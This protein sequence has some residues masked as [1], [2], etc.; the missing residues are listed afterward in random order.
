MTTDTMPSIASSKARSY[1]R[2]RKRTSRRSARRR[3]RDGLRVT[4]PA[5]M[6]GVISG[7]LVVAWEFPAWLK[8]LPVRGRESLSPQ[9]PTSANTRRGLPLPSTILSG[10]ATTTAPVA[11]S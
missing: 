10:A 4:F 5:L 9:A 11:G 6:L 8:V 1:R 7:L 3:F 2:Y